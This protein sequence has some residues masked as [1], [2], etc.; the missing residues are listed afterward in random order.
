V[1]DG[2]SLKVQATSGAATSSDAVSLG[3]IVTVLVINALKHAFQIGPLKSWSATTLGSLAEPYR[4]RTM[5]R[6]LE[7]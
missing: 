6:D 5:A 4:Y 1:I 2:R 3:L 7:T